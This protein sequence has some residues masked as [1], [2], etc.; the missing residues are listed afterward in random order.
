MPVLFVPPQVA[1]VLVDHREVESILQ[2]SPQVAPTGPL[3]NLSLMIL[4]HRARAPTK[5]LF[6]KKTTFP[7]IFLKY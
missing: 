4:L 1:E 5:A 3:P 6:I 2:N 7:T